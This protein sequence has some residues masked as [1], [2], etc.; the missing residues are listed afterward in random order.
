MSFLFIFSP[1]FFYY[2]QETSYIFERDVILF[3]LRIGIHMNDTKDKG[4]KKLED[5]KRKFDDLD[6]DILVRLQDDARRSYREIASDLQVSVGTVHNRIKRLMKSGILIGFQPV[7]NSKMLGYELCF[8]ILV[9][10][11][12][13]HSPE[14]LDLVKNNLNVRS[15]YHTTGDQSA[16]LICRFK[17]IEDARE[18]ISEISQNKYVEKIVSNL[19]L[20][21]V[22]EEPNVNIR[23]LEE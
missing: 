23:V 8:L 21:V 9:T 19:V 3:Q 17:K 11:R 15:I 10:I 18:F 12:G 16:A 14:V 6:R 1:F 7:L 22:K 4:D 5:K 2:V 20:D 13:G